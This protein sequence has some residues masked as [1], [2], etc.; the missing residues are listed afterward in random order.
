MGMRSS[1]Q[2]V[3]IHS[4]GAF[5]DPTGAYSKRSYPR[6]TLFRRRN[7]AL[8]P[9]LTHSK[10][11]STR[12]TLRAT[13]AQSTLRPARLYDPKKHAPQKNSPIYLDSAAGGA[14]NTLERLNECSIVRAKQTKP[15]QA[16]RKFWQQHRRRDASDA[17]TV[18]R[19]SAHDA[20]LR[21]R[22]QNGK[23]ERHERVHRIRRE[24]Q[25]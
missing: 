3:E 11:S 9:A 18:T 6:T 22:K 14:Y 2:A 20:R 13:L 16:K 25:G 19:E 15:A 10:R 17:L 4:F 23:A 7:Y 8:E 21:A 24:T 1:V 5:L 12:R